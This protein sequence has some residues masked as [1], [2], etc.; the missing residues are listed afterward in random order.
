[1]SSSPSITWIVS[2]TLLL[3]HLVNGQMYRSIE[4]PADQRQLGLFSELGLSAINYCKTPDGQVGE[5]GEISRCLYLLFDMV[6]LRRSVCF[7]NLFMVGICCPQTSTT[8][9]TT[10]TEASFDNVTEAALVAAI[11]TTPETTT[12]STT[13]STTTTTPKPKLSTVPVKRFQHKGTKKPLLSSGQTTTPKPTT[14]TIKGIEIFTT[15]SK[16]TD[17][18][19]VLATEASSPNY[20]FSSS[21]FRCGTSGRDGRIVGGYEANPGQWPWMAAIFLDNHRGREYWCGG[22]L[23]GTWYILTAA[24]CLSD[25][26]GRKYRKEHLTVR[27]GDH[28]LF[29]SDDFMEP[30]E[31]K[32]SEALPHPRFSRSGFYND[33]ALLKLRSPVHYTE[34]VSPVCLPTPGLKA[35]TL[36]GY[37]GTVTGW[38]TLS[39]GGTGS[40]SLQQVTMPIWDNTD[41]NR[42]YFQPITQGFLCAG[43]F[44]GGKDACQGDSGSPMVIPDRTRHWTVVGVVSFGSKCAQPGYPGVYT[45]VTEYLDW[46]DENMQ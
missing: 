24:H 17:E 46:I 2:V 31:F 3:S 21:A 28:H 32:V 41:C 43:F 25:Q 36:V 27:L 9:T 33:I 5:C 35:N 29:R 22:A 12:V 39:Y 13:T 40:G 19:Y 42:R 23:I 4:D 38:G 37:M 6:R 10:T 11:E 8:T 14:T 44:E 34:A 26:R 30:I 45:R 15:D 16:D 1:M 18:P 20:T 7:R